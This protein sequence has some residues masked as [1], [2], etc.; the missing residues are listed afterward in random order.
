MTNDYKPLLSGSSTASIGSGFDENFDGRALGSPSVVALDDNSFF[1]SW[2][3]IFNH[4][5]GSVLGQK[6]DKS[7][8]AIGEIIVIT[9]RGPGHTSQRLCKQSDLTK[10]D[11]GNIAVVYRED[12]MMQLLNP[13]VR[14]L[15]AQFVSVVEMVGQVMVEPGRP[16]QQL[17]MEASLHFGCQVTRVIGISMGKRL[18]ILAV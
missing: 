11:N 6:I 12:G 17:T 2:V 18:I 10:L 14:L 3:S 16:L 5:Y 13:M 9:D 8:N 7:G 4:N 1:V 15:A